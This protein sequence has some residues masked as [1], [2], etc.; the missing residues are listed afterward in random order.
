MKTF[1]RVLALM[2]AALLA[3]G[4]LAA[5]HGKDAV[6][7]TYAANG[8]TYSLTSGQYAYLLLVADQEARSKVSEELTDAEKNAADNGTEIDVF[9][10]TLD[11]KDYVTWV[12]DRAVELIREYFYVA[13]EFDRLELEL[14]ESDAG[15]MESYFSY[16]WSMYGRQYLC[17]PNGCSYDSF[18]AVQTV[19]LYERNTLFQY[20]YGPDGP[21]PVSDEEKT[22]AL[23]ENYVLA[24]VITLD[25]STLKEEEETT[26]TGETG[27]TEETE[28]TEQTEEEAAAEKAALLEKAKAQLQGYADRINGGTAF[29]VIYYEYTGTTPP[30]ETEDPDA[31]SAGTG[32]E[33]PAEQTEELK[34]QDPLAAVYQADSGDDV[35]ASASTNLYYKIVDCEIGK[36]T[37]VETNDDKVALLLRQD[38]TADPYYAQQYKDNVLDILKGETF[39]DTVSEGG[40]KLDVTVND[41]ERDHIDV[42]KIDYTQYNAYINALYSQYGG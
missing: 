32:S 42:K 21:D 11:D 37:V 8:K 25:P 13:S 40:E 39:N 16:M 12:K 23:E 24:D 7:A 20:L 4:C 2:L 9:S 35:D 27:E 33:E 19:L 6:V 18:K 41:Y 15:S 10:K 17:E 31:S 26:E 14:S 5:C 3:F 28:E 36:A 22:A 1:A 34:A 30:E 29:S 38:I